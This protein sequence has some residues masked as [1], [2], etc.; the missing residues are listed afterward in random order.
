VDDQ[1]RQI[2]AGI[3]MSQLVTD[4]G[5]GEQHSFPDEAT[6]EMISQALGLGGIAG[7]AALAN[8]PSNPSEHMTKMLGG[9]AAEGL[10]ELAGAP[11]SIVGMIPKGAEALAQAVPA[12]AAPSGQIA[13]L[14]RPEALP[15][16]EGLTTGLRDLG[17]IGQ[18]IQQ[19]QNEG[20]RLMAAGMRGAVGTAPLGALSGAAGI[21]KAALQGGLSGLGGEAGQNVLPLSSNPMISG[22]AGVLAGQGAAGGLY[23]MAGRGLNAA[24]GVGNPV[25]DA[26]D[27]AGVA[28]RLAGDVTGRPGL[29]ALQSLAMRAPFGGRAVEAAQ[30]GASEF[31][32]SIERAAANLGNARTATDAGLALQA[33]G[34]NWMQ[35]FR[36]AQQQAEAAVSARVPPTAPVSMAPVSRVL[37]QT[38][39]EMPDAP[40][41]AAM[42]TNP[43]FRGLSESLAGDLRNPAPYL[44]DP[45][46][47][48]TGTV[49]GTP[50]SR[51]ALE[52][53][54]ARA[55]RTKVG[56]QLETSLVSRDGNDKAWK[57][58]YGALSDALGGTA[59]AAGAGREWQA[60]NTVTNRGHQFIENT[61]S[62]IIDHPGAQNTVRPEDAAR[63]ALGGTGAGGTTLNDLRS[64]MPQSV[65][66]LAAFKLRDMASA[67][68]GRATQASPTSATTF[69][70]EL[71]R[72]SPEAR[73]A[74]FGSY[75]PGLDALQTVAERGKETFQRYGNPS[76]TAGMTQ[77]GGLLN[78]PLQITAA[79]YGGH[80]IGGMP[81]A[82]VG[83]GTATLP[84]LTGPIASNLTAREALT[85]Y[86]AAPTG[87]PGTEMSRLFRG[88]GAL[89][90][91]LPGQATSN[92]PGR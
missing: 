83:A 26:Y 9:A 42:M 60:A 25:I 54:T 13:S 24:R 10:A 46:Y 63:F 18:P 44:N 89:P 65:N 5:T 38:I 32:N 49:P 31:G 84:Y 57:R 19:P 92:A 28:P 82:I 55:W 12:L 27:A 50:T 68:P 85:R 90:F 16:S 21:A 74:L 70:T 41:V 23:G 61:L 64:M 91:V 15:T 78:A 77:H 36:A 58:I 72:L 69:S 81:G 88:A 51:A 48:T 86:L 79:G 73:N 59:T 22:L 52:W 34:R 37:E 40:R 20:E 87:G 8:Q 11:G 29:Q 35:Q 53:D 4:P 47:A 67:T 39:S 6:P 45:L 66:E 1:R 3:A 80:E 76:G 43:V 2:G 7:L 71:N 62:N 30:A 75:N 17:A 33:G 56:E 14:V